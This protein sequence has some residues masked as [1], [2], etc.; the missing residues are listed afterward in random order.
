MSAILAVPVPIEV[1]AMAGPGARTVAD[2][3][4]A[5]TSRDQPGP[6]S[7]WCGRPLWRLSVMSL[8]ILRTGLACALVHVTGLGCPGQPLPFGRRGQVEDDLRHPGRP[9]PEDLP[10]RRLRCAPGAGSKL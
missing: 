7:M 4:S 5:S 8:P 9:H 3:P 10:L 2:R 6:A 1:M